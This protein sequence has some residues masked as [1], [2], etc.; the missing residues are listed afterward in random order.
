MLRRWP[1]ALRLPVAPRGV[2]TLSLFGSTELPE[3]ANGYDTRLE[4][5]ARRRADPTDVAPFV[6]LLEEL[7]TASFRKNVA[8]ATE[9]SERVQHMLLYAPGEELRGIDPQHVIGLVRAMNS[10]KYMP[11]AIGF[12]RAVTRLL[13]ATTSY[14]TAEDAATMLVLLAIQD[15]V[16]HRDV[17]TTLVYIVFAKAADEAGQGLAELSEALVIQLAGT[18]PSFEHLL[19]EADARRLFQRVAAIYDAGDAASTEI[20]LFVSQL[21][22]V[23][24]IGQDQLAPA[25]CSH[26]VK[27]APGLSASDI[28]TVLRYLERADVAPF[29]EKAVAALSERLI[30]LVQSQA[31]SGDV[32]IETLFDA[33]HQPAAALSLEENLYRKLTHVVVTVIQNVISVAVP[34]A[35]TDT[36]ASSDGRCAVCGA[37]LAWQGVAADLGFHNCHIRGVG[38]LTLRGHIKALELLTSAGIKPDGNAF[39]CILFFWLCNRVSPAT[40]ASL[41]RDDSRRLR[42]LVT[43]FSDDGLMLRSGAV[44]LPMKFEGAK[45]QE[46]SDSLRSFLDWQMNAHRSR[47]AWPEEGRGVSDGELEYAPKK[48]LRPAGDIGLR[49]RYRSLG[50]YLEMDDG[51]QDRRG[52]GGTRPMRPSLA[53]QRHNRK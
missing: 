41:N 4:W 43:T 3:I 33:L 20:G 42:E 34:D 10:L 40:A 36:P 26:F 53:A 8:E 11:I 51:G 21:M 28:R 22:A 39:S 23:T 5:Q 45:A 6:G 35:T 9:L 27:S 32:E 24:I 37:Q 2:R 38:S 12:S 49:F 47:G 1:A 50:A 31:E 13:C 52:G 17:V 25:L 16:Y 46:L 19:D 14:F 48:H 30:R 29:S 7:T 15:A 18:L 44:V